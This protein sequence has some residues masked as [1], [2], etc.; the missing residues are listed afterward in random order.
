MPEK[1]RS[2]AAEEMLCLNP[3]ANIM[4]MSGYTAD[5]IKIEVS[6]VIQSV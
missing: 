1:N 3:K 4:F 5:F 6:T 2:D